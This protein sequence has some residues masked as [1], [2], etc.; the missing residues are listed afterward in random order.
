MI[1]IKCPKCSHAFNVRVPIPPAPPLKSFKP[2]SLVT[3]IVIG[4]GCVFLFICIALINLVSNTSTP[5]SVRTNYSS[6]NDEG[7]ILRDNIWRDRVFIL[8]V[9]TIDGDI[10]DKDSR[11]HWNYKWSTW[12]Y[13]KKKYMEQS[14]NDLL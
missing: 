13:E 12:N 6:S 4:L 9:K 14:L 2:T 5:G 3:K 8:M 1:R 10:D 11:E 7:R